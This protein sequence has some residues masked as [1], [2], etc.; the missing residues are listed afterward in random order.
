MTGYV[1]I[2]DFRLKAG[3]RKAF[4]PLM[5]ANARDSVANEAGCQQFDVVEPTGEPDR[6]LLYEIYADRAAFDLHLKA[7]H[8]LS[9]DA[10]SAPLVEQKI[11]T[12]GE[13]VS[14]G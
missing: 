6:I 4:R 12:F 3:Q 8:Y 7:Q 13:R 11:V 10:A 1:V 5:D 14:A 9:F 2:V